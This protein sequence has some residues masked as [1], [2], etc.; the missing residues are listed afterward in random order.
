[1]RVEQGKVNLDSR[2]LARRPGNNRVQ[3]GADFDLGLLAGVDCAVDEEGHIRPDDLGDVQPQRLSIGADGLAGADHAR[4]AAFIVLVQLPEVGRQH[5]CVLD[6]Q[7]Q[8]VIDEGVRPI[9][10][11][12]ADILIRQRLCALGA[13]AR[14]REEFFARECKI[15]GQDTASGFAVRR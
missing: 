9:L 8:E 6:A 1:M 7:R 2:T 15:V 13:G 5:G 11:E 14:G 3:H 10:V 4:A 12:E